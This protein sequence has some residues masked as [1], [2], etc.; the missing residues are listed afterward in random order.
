[1]GNMMDRESDVL[2]MCCI[3]LFCYPIPHKSFAIVSP[4]K[5]VPPPPKISLLLYFLNNVLSYTPNFFVTHSQILCYPTP[6]IFSTLPPIY[7]ATL[8]SEK[9]FATQPPKSFITQPQKFY[10]YTPKHF[11]PPYLE[12]N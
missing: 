2:A 12:K 11:L 7:F 8:P 10:H 5:F 3:P 4:N 9:F 6:K 1:M